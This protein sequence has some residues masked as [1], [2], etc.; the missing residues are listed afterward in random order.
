MRLLVLPRD[1]HTKRVAHLIQVVVLPFHDRIRIPI[2]GLPHEGEPHLRP[3]DELHMPT[4]ERIDV[5]IRIKAPVHAEARLPGVQV[6]RLAHEL[7]KR[8]DV[9]DVAS[10]LAVIEG[11]A[12]LRSQRHAEVDL[13]QCNAVLVA[14]PSEL[15]ERIGVRRDRRSVVVPA[16]AI[17]QTRRAGGTEPLLG[18]LPEQGEQLAC[19]LGRN[20]LESPDASPGALPIRRRMALARQVCRHGEHLRRAAVSED[21]A[22]VIRYA[23]LASGSF[24]DKPLAA[25]AA[26]R[27]RI[28]RKDT[29]THSISCASH[30]SHS[31]S[32]DM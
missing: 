21:E 12:A 32:Q 23:A 31:G 6:C 14:A 11:Q 28:G 5:R 2:D 1:G 13:R 25:E 24:D 18:R 10:G 3:D 9:G 27:E 30:K 16:L 17:G 8:R 19:A 29:D 15:R 26:A 4:H 22:E 7:A 20:L